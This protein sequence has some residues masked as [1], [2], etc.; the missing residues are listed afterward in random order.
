MPSWHLVVS[1]E[2][3]ALIASLYFTLT[4]NH[5]FLNSAL[6]GRDW[7]DHKTWLLA[8][9]LLLAITGIHTALFLILFSRRTAKPL[10]ITLLV[11]TAAASY[12]MNRYT[13]FFNGEMIRNILR[14]DFKEASELL[15]LDMLLHILLYAGVPIALLSRMHIAKRRWTRTLWIRPLCVIAAAVVTVAAVLPVFQD[16][17]AMMRNQKEMRFLIMP[18]AYLTSFTRVLASDGKQAATGRI[19]I[20]EDARLGALWAHRSKPMLFVLVVGETTRAANWGLNGYAR[21][22]TP[23]LASLEGIINFPY[24]TSCGTNTEVSVPCMFSPFGRHDYDEEKIRSH[25]SLL[26]LIHRTGISTV[27]RDNQSGCKGV[28]D[29]LPMTH[30]DTSQKSPLCDG[31]RCLDDILTEGMDTDIQRAPNG[32]VFVVLHQLGNHGP[33]YYKRYPP[34]LRRFVPTCDTADLGKC[35]K[36]QIVNAYDNGVLGTDRMLASTIAYLKTQTHYDTAMLYLSDHGESLGEHGI[37]LHGLPYSIAPKEQTQIPMVMWMS[38]GFSSSFGINRDCISRRANQP[39]SQDHLFH[40]LLGLLRIESKQYDPAW[41][42]FKG[43]RA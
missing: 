40:S 5:L 6:Q 42:A 7:G 36:E 15:S 13:V 14:T 31:E 25:E 27:W 1:A 11:I 29:G 10:L 21:Q 37:F 22:T 20:S 38:S 12:Y 34:E 4:A 26:H 39:I 18:G 16:F 43:C 41:D 2:L 9:A 35:T 17:S 3:L 30:I 19:S 8:I 23:R 32:N 24:A 33:A 28:C